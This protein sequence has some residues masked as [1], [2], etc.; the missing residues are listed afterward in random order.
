MGVFLLELQENGGYYLK[1]LQLDFSNLGS[2]N[3]E[4]SSENTGMFMR[5]YF[6]VVLSHMLHVSCQIIIFHQPT[7][8]WN[9]RGF[10]LLNHHLG[11]L[12]VWGRELIWTR[13]YGMFSYTC[14]IFFMVKSM[15]VSGSPKKVGS[16]AYNPPIGSKNTTYIPLIVLAF[17]GV[18][19][20]TDPTF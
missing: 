1:S 20:A 2:E 19:N 10:P 5:S 8:P 18:K 15:V 17:W 13:W 12:V 3:D 16:V 6:L 14:L 7:F 4:V 9:S 11:I